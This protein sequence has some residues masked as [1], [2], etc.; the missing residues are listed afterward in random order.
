MLNKGLEKKITRSRHFPWKFTLF[1][2]AIS[3]LWI[4]TSDFILNLMLD[5]PDHL[6]FF[7]TIK[8]YLFIIIT[9]A[10]FYFYLKRENSQTITFYN[11]IKEN[12]EERHLSNE[13]FARIPQGLV[14]ADA[15]GRILKVNESFARMTGFKQE[16]LIGKRYYRV[17]H[18]QQTDVPFREIA[19]T[20]IRKGKWQGEIVTLNKEGIETPEYLTVHQI[21]NQEGEVLYYFGIFMD[22][23]ELK[24]KEKA[25][26]ETKDQLHSIVEHSPLAI[27]VCN[28]N[29]YVQFYNQKA[30]Q[31]LHYSKEQAIGRK[32]KE[33]IPGVDQELRQ[34][35]EDPYQ[36]YKGFRCELDTHIPDGEKRILEMSFSP[37]HKQNGELNGIQMIFS[38]ITEHYQAQRHIEY[39]RK[40]DLN[41]GLYNYD[42]F[43]EEV[44]DYLERYPEESCAFLFIDL[45]RFQLINDKYGI[46]FGDQVVREVAQRLKQSLDKRGI[47]GRL[48][49]DEF[50]VFLQNVKDEKNV[51]N[52]AREIF[53]QFTEPFMIKNQPIHLTISMGISVYPHDGQELE[54]LEKNANLAV[55]RAKKER[56]AFR[57]FDDSMNEDVDQFD[58][59]YELHQAIREEELMVY[60]QPQIKLDTG[61]L[62]GVEAL[63]RWKHPE[64]G[65]VSPEIFIPIAEETGL[66][67]PLT[68]FVLK[69]VCEDILYWKEHHMD[70]PSISIN[71]SAKQFFHENLVKEFTDILK[72]YQVSNDRIHIEIT[73][74]VAMDIGQSMEKLKQLQELGFKISIDDFGTGY[75]SLKYLKEL[76]IDYIKID[77]TFISQI[78]EDASMVDA[79]LHL[80]SLCQLE[81][82]GEGIETE[83]QREY[84]KHAGCSI[85]QGYYFSK[86]VPRDEINKEIMNHTDA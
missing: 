11:E 46:Y 59:E 69:K 70:I 25:L 3:L 68:N 7:Q 81:A 24:E 1:Y 33:V 77:R 34:H 51:Q 76:P 21:Q 54:E 16:E 39:L 23:T 37:L 67:V 32:I 53:D 14:I 4:S 26:F 31:I 52:M 66:I 86:P 10:L 65:F 62:W 13:V 73:E 19:R 50:A 79:I 36:L 22:L 5:D 47:V 49:G 43:H 45:D 42:I 64:K 57:F 6:T 58:F 55:T 85:G 15:K 75:S 30:E 60:Y 9:S 35:S 29:G 78:E 2:F 80:A 63:L 17:K 40:F 18:V 38:D 20:V 41:T 27:V 83:S 74:S 56:N 84:L 12:E 48:K 82:V 8:G 72:E 71:L 28:R 61:E 44:R